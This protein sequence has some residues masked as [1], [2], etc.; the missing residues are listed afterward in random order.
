MKTLIIS[1]NPER[2]SFRQIEIFKDFLQNKVQ[3][4]VDIFAL[5]SKSLL[6]N[7]RVISKRTNALRVLEEIEA[8]LKRGLYSFY[9]VSL[10]AENLKKI[11]PFEKANFLKMAEKHS[12]NSNIFIFGAPS[13][14]NNIEKFREKLKVNVFL[15]PRH[16]VAKITDEFKKQIL[17]SV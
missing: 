15:T 9:I 12:K 3:N 17:N 2:Q 14:L 13:I 6:F 7:N 10:E 11:F 16:G 1:D 4:R 5:S 8:V